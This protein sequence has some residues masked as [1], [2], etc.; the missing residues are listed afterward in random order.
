M[1]CKID[2]C[3]TF[4]ICRQN[5]W[6]ILVKW[7][8]VL[9]HFIT[10]QLGSYC[11]FWNYWNWE[12]S[13][14]RTGKYKIMWNLQKIK[15]DTNLQFYHFF[16][17]NSG[18]RVLLLFKYFNFPCVFFKY[19]FKF[20]SFLILAISNPGDFYKLLQR[21]KKSRQEETRLW[22]RSKTN[23]N[24]GVKN[25]DKQTK[26][27]TCHEY[28][29]IIFI[30]NFRVDCPTEFPLITIFLELSAPLIR[31]T[32]IQIHFYKHLSSIKRSW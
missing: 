8:I 29:A 2:S 32:F 6:T 4:L 12:S 14:V 7:F 30:T 19:E 26:R 1:S 20:T 5:F 27:S 21:L 23:K 22:V 10:D 17:I 16:F 28:P 24:D 11:H 13:T 9:L 15:N 3:K 18:L 31:K 25:K